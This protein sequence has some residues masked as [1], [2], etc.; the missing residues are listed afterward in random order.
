M[1]KRILF[2]FLGL[3]LFAA[4]PALFFCKMVLAAGVSQVSSAENPEPKKTT[5]EEPRELGTEEMLEMIAG[6]MQGLSASLNGLPEPPKI[7][8]RVI[9]LPKMESAAEENADKESIE[10]QPAEEIPSDENF[11]KEAKTEN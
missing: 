7:K 6:Q 9:Q 4:S 8:N 3:V 1:R 2:F 10:E 11:L 5:G